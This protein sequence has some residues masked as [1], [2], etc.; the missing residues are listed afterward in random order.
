[1]DLPP[2]ITGGQQARLFSSLKLSNKEQIATATLLAVFRL[3][4]ELLGNLISD[5]GVRINNRTKFDAF[6]EVHLSKTKGQKNDR[7]DGF[8]YVKNRNEWTALVEAKVGNSTLSLEQVIR[9]AEDARANGINAVITISNEFTPR[10]EQSPLEIPK[11]L[12]SRVRIYHLSWRLILSTA[13]LMRNRTDIEDREKLFVIDELIRFLRDDS[14]GNKSFTMMPTSWNEV[15]AE[16]SMGA[17]LKLS[18]ERVE[19]VSNALVEEFSEIALN[20]TDHLGVDC[21]AKIPTSFMSDRGAW[22]KSITRSICDQ[23]SASCSFNIPNAADTLDV[24]ID[25]AK[26]SISVGMEIRVPEERSTL[27]G[28][29]NWVIRQLRNLEAP[30][31]F[32]KVRWKSRAADEFIEMG[33]FDANFFQGRQLNTTILSLTPLMQL[34]SSRLFGSRKNFITELEALVLNFYDEHAQ[35]LKQWQPSAPKPLPDSDGL[36]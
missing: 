22:Q 34:H 4:P 9:Y 5:T 35:Y 31:S 12:Q 30:N 14:V 17:R 28:K 23:K 13:I 7:P 15:C 33:K 3:V 20:L 24:H 2:Q 11:R 27:S 29:I 16:A 6:T 25:L 32:V 21:S 8:L 10:V 19:N 1:M 18:D 36:D 26:N